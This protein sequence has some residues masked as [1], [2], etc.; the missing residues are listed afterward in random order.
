MKY[1]QTFPSIERVAQANA[2]WSESELQN[3]YSF[4]LYFVA[5]RYMFRVPGVLNVLVANSITCIYNS[6]L[7]FPKHFD[8]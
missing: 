5:S 6:K 3:T 1:M 7:R 8:T 4:R 2:R